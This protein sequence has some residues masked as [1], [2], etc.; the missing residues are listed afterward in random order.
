MSVAHSRNRNMM[1]T[2]PKG[3]ERGQA[4]KPGSY[5]GPG[6]QAVKDLEFLF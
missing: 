1:G 3:S 5:A 4:V 2:R 6:H